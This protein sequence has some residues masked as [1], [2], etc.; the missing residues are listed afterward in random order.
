MLVAFEHR[1]DQTFFRWLKPG[2][3][4]CYLLRRTAHGW[5]AIDPMSAPLLCAQG[6]ELDPSLL[7]SGLAAA[8]VSTV[9]C[10]PRRYARHCMR[11]RIMT[12]V[13]WVKHALYLN[14][15]NVFTPYQ[16]FVRLKAP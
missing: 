5:F 6:A 1:P 2:F 9:I 11:V 10:E 3:R 15:G 4:H 13:E 8:G 7:A 14:G 12:C 16:L